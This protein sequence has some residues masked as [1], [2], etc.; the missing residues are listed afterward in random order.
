MAHPMRPIW[1]LRGYAVGRA[2]N[3]PLLGFDAGVELLKP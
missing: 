3:D 1:H 2:G